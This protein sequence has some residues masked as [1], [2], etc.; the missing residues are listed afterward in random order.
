ML[1]SRFQNPIDQL[2]QDTIQFQSRFDV[3]L[4]QLVPGGFETKKHGV[5]EKIQQANVLFQELEL[6]INRLQGQLQDKQLEYVLF[7]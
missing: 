2:K 6:E 3:W 7:D 5:L 1:A 4:Q